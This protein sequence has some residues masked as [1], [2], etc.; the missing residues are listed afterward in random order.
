MKTN[1]ALLWIGLFTLAGAATISCGGSSDNG[2]LFTAGNAG[3]AAGS[4]TTAGTNATGGVSS[5]AGMTSNTAGA[6]NNAAGTN[7][8]T[9]GTNSNTAG[10]NNNTAGSNNNTAGSNNNTGGRS[11]P[12]TGGAPEPGV[13]GAGADG[14]PATMPTDG[15][16]CAEGDSPF[17]GCDYGTMSCRC[18]RSNGGG[19]MRAWRCETEED[20]D[21]VCPA[22]AMDGDPCT[23]Q[24]PCAGQQCFCNNEETNCF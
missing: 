17:Q 21:A 23:G 4:T 18:R 16:M 11:D 20:A 1:T 8:N 5:T 6:N 19:Q 14:C 22:N 10:S 24:G 9:A 2:G 15:A 7:S 12:G 3:N 13:G